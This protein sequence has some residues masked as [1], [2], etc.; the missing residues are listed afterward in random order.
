MHDPQVP[1]LCPH[2]TGTG[3]PGRPTRFGR[4]GAGHHCPVEDATG[5]RGAV[6]RGVQ[7]LRL[8]HR[9]DPGE[10]RAIRRSVDRWAQQNAMPDEAVID[11]QLALGEAVSNGVEHAY[12][13]GAT[14]TVDVELEIRRAGR[15]QVVAV[16]VVDHGRWRPAQQL[17]SYR[18]R[19]L[20]MIERLSRDLRV[21]STG[22][23]TQVFFDIPLP[24]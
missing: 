17:Q 4:F 3:H 8:R 5:S 7:R 15:A 18:G 1:D 2:D 24:G 20:A 21:S 10:L 11:L 16:R 23:G 12:A 6:R 19:G 14:G 22:D 13:E 9:A